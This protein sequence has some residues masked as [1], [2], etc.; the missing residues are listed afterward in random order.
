MNPGRYLKAR[1][2]LAAGPERDC[3]LGAFEHNRPPPGSIGPL[4]RQHR[5]SR[6]ST[7][8]G[9]RRLECVALA[10]EDIALGVKRIRDFLQTIGAS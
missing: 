6:P 7:S 5:V 4:I 10:R 8:F 2:I 1:K 9:K 3:I